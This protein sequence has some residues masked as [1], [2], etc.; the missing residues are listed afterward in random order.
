[1]FREGFYKFFISQDLF[2]QV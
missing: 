2:I 1:M